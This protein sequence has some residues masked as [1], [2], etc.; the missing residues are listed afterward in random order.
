MPRMS[1]E[2]AARVTG[3]V[4]DI[5]AATGDGLALKELVD[6]L[7]GVPGYLDVATVINLLKFPMCV[8]PPRDSLLRSLET[9]TGKAFGGDVWRLVEQASD[10]GLAPDALVTPPTRRF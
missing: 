8:G 4:I 9:R 5:M 2:S 6:A 10:L 3:R 1:S 7:A